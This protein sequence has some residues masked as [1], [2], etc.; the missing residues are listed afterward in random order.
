MRWVRL[1]RICL[2]QVPQ[3]SEWK[4]LRRVG[5]PAGMGVPSGRA[6]CC[7]GSCMNSMASL[8]GSSAVA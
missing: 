1:G 5:Y 6:R 2:T 8:S 4:E 3:S 7:C